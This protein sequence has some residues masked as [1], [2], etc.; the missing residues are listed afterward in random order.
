VTPLAGS[1]SPHEVEVLQGHAAGLVSRSI[2][3]VIDAAVVALML[4]GLY[5]AVSAAILV[6]DPRGFALPAW[7]GVVTWTTAGLVATGYLSV[8]WWT[9]G[10]TFGCAV[11][12]LRV[13]SRDGDVV[14]LWRAVLR[15]LVCIFF[16]FGLVWS[17]VDG[18]SR[19]VHDLL[20]G[21]RVIYDWRHREG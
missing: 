13:Q 6:W 14:R 16:P 8:G 17:A 9:A 21:S 4:L 12:G 10:R 20:V 19:A 15:A 7:S 5:A 3:A 18:R 11:M 2:A 1:P